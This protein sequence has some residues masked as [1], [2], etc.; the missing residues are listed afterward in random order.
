MVKETG[1]Y[2]ELGISPDATEQQIRSAYRSKA[3]QYHPDKNNGD[4][5]AAE[6]F[7]KVSE[8]YE[9]LSDADRRKQYDTF[10]RNGPGGAA[11]GSGGFPG[12]FGHGFGPGMDPMDIFS[13]FFGFAA[14]GGPGKSQQQRPAKPSFILVELQCSLEELYCGTT[15]VLLVRRRR[16]CPTCQGHGTSNGQ[17]SPVCPQCKGNKTVMKGLSFGGLMTYQ[18]C[19]CDRCQG[20]GKLPIQFPCARC[21]PIYD[22][23]QR[24]QLSGTL[25]RGVVEEEK[26]IKVTIA[27]GAEDSDALNYPGQGDELPGFDAAGDILVVVVQLPHPHY[28]RLN[29]TDLLLSNCRLPLWSLFRDAFSIPVE[30]LDGR[31]VRLAPPLREDN[32]PHFLFDSHH[33]FVVE[34]EGMP[35]KAQTNGGA[36][37]DESGDG[38]GSAAGAAHLKKGKLYVCINV[39]FPHSLTPAQMD[40]IT[41]VLGGSGECDRDA[42]AGDADSVVTLQPHH[43]PAPSWHRVDAEGNA[44]YKPRTAAAAKRKK[45]TRAA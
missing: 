12:G 24:A 10:G 40:A 4:L 25:P 38:S 36:A 21:G 1:L 23:H 43:G 29:S 3:L 20:L 44:W 35:L 27:P 22:A 41:K 34:N 30:L 37:A 19:R 9:I 28:H 33:V 15:K 39:V 26:K 11:G 42:T 14:G 6:K 7:K 5:A 18:Q 13:S 2:D 8:A 17:P 32:V 45:P 31:V 16:R